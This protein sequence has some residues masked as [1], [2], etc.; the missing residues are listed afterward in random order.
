[1]GWGRKPSHEWLGYFQP[2]KAV[3]KRRRALLVSAAVK[4]IGGKIRETG[5]EGPSF[6]GLF[7]C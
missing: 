4:E 5:C 6:C 2:A 1:M 3:D 7:R